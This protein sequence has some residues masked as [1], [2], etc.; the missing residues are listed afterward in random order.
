M[1]KENKK[2]F[3][4]IVECADKTF[5]TGYT[6]DLKKRLEK[7]NNGVASKYTRARLPVRLVWYSA[8]RQLSGALRSEAMIKKLTRNQ[9]EF[10]LRGE[11]FA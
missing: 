2:H 8:Y 11:C 4:Y 5:Y 1:V 10:L 9:K 6:N 3:V 7:H